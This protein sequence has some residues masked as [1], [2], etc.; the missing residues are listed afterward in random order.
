MKLWQR[1]AAY[2]AMLGVLLLVPM[3]APKAQAQDPLMAGTAVVAEWNP[4]TAVIFITVM[5]TYW[6]TVYLVKIYYEN[7]QVDTEFYYDYAYNA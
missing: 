3:A 1:I 7:G 2:T 6:V 4:V 5:A